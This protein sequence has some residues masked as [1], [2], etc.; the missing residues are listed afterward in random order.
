M[1]GRQGKGEEEWGKI[2][3]N[4]ELGKVAW[5][6]GLLR[7]LHPPIPS[8]KSLHYIPLNVSEMQ[9][10]LQ[11]IAAIEWI[12]PGISIWAQNN[13]CNLRGSQWLDTQCQA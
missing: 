7:L 10:C 1:Q 5:N 11:I 9:L 13:P 8:H 4:P 6:Q 2:E 3:C 12:R